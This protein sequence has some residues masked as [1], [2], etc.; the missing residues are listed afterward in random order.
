MSSTLL[1]LPIFD[2]GQFLYLVFESLSGRQI[3][4]RL[5]RRFRLLSIFLLLAFGAVVF[6][7]N[8]VDLLSP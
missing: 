4:S 1:P 7:L 5:K 3:N 8:L 2:G 6:L